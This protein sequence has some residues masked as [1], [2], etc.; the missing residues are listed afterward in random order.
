MRRR[1]QSGS[2]I[3]RGLAVL[4]VAV[5]GAM[6]APVRAEPPTVTLDGA[7][8]AVLAGHPDVARDAERIRRSE[9]A[10]KQAEAVFV[11]GIVS[12]RTTAET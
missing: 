9:G 7:I 1:R 6:G 5:A 11:L 2:M 10:V 12:T 3:V 4:V 8:G